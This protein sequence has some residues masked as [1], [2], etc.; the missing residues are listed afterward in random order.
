VI[1]DAEHVCLDSDDDGSEQTASKKNL[2]IKQTTQHN[3]IST[4]PPPAKKPRATTAAASLKDPVD[5]E[6][7]ARIKVDIAAAKH[8]VLS[9]EASSTYMGDKAQHRRK[10]FREV[11]V[12]WMVNN[13]R[14]DYDDNKE[15]VVY[16]WVD[17]VYKPS[18]AGQK[19]IEEGVIK[20]E[21]VY[22]GPADP[23]SLPGRLNDVLTCTTYRNW[24]DSK[25]FHN[26]LL[27]DS[28]VRDKNKRA[29]RI[30]LDDPV[31]TMAKLAD[32]YG[33]DVSNVKQLFHRL[34]M[35]G[36]IAAWRKDHRVSQNISDVDLVVQ[37]QK[38]MRAATQDMYKSVDP[39]KRAEL[40]EY[41]RSEH[42]KKKTKEAF[43]PERTFKH[44]LL[45]ETEWKSRQAKRAVFREL[46][47]Q[48]GSLEHDGIKEM[49]TAASPN[50]HEKAGRLTEAASRAV[51]GTVPVVF[52]PAYWSECEVRAIPTKSF[53][54]FD[55]IPLRKEHQPMQEEISDL[56]SKIESFAK[57]PD[58]KI[59]D[60]E[61]EQNEADKDRLA[62]LEEEFRKVNEPRIAMYK[63]IHGD[64]ALGSRVDEKNAYNIISDFDGRIFSTDLGLVMYDNK[65]GYWTHDEQEHHRLVL[66]RSEEVIEGYGS[67]EAL[68]RDAIK[69]V[70]CQAPKDDNFLA[71]G[72][73]KR[74]G[75]L[76]YANGVLDMA[77]FEMKP[78][79]PAYRFVDRINRNFYP[80]EQHDARIA[81]I[82]RRLLDKPFTNE[83]K[84]DFFLQL[85]ARGVA[86]HV[87]DK[88]FLVAIGESNCG[89]GMITKLLLNALGGNQGFAATFNCDDLLP[90]KFKSEAESARKWTWLYGI[91][92]KRMIIGNEVTAITDTVRRGARTEERVRPF[93]SNTIKIL[94]PGGDLIKMRLLF[95]KH[96][97]MRPNLAFVFMLAN[98]VPAFEPFDKAV[99]KRANHIE[100]DRASSSTIKVYTDK[101]FVADT[102]MDDWVQR[103]EVGDAFIAVLCNSYAASLESRMPKPDYVV[104]AVQERGTDGRGTLKD[105]LTSK[106]KFYSGPITDFHSGEFS[107][108]GEPLFDGE[109]V[110]NWKVP[111]DWL[112]QDWTGEGNRG[113]KINFG[114]KLT[115]LGLPSWSVKMRNDQLNTSKVMRCRVG[116]CKR[117]AE[118]DDDDGLPV[119]SMEFA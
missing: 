38:E 34:S 2:A 102:S 96:E 97:A 77:N 64:L 68:F 74:K 14:I 56:E 70:K 37:F 113:S 82:Y 67:F 91:A 7:R 58:D 54:A 105:W 33:V 5:S 93:D 100:F 79:D 78:K 98:D 99:E 23:F 66:D 20:G 3:K 57:K 60:G 16:G 29:L 86:G 18:E 10:T 88:Q 76:L 48:H 19:F 1:D 51:G 69:T 40:T 32:H 31:G 75:H 116:L 59:K 17:V 22:G 6:D 42:E 101:E 15:G 85:I 44:Y 110:G 43:H 80:G 65:G 95:Q 30:F 73:E 11:M 36:S 71:A 90:S 111:F 50:H 26:Y 115:E 53:I 28:R 107:A 4:M 89:K 52:K 83:G 87:E 61:E 72:A 109:K 47:L 12:G 84:R 117:T 108:D 41:L 39:G 25:A 118:D 21:R 63:Y 62:K 55:D 9:E 45:A 13:V 8:Y 119:V 24:D 104:K 81:E 92:S 114:K 103:P 46:G 35:D 112:F 49:Y 106:Y 27:N 94:S